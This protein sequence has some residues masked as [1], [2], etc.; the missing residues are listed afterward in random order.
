MI[1]TSA[2]AGGRLFLKKAIKCVT[3]VARRARRYGSGIRSPGR[4][5]GG[6]AGNGYAR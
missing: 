4:L 6:I 2:K 3:R 1:L 5:V